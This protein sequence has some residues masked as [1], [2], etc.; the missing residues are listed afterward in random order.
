MMD[1]AQGM[2]CYVADKVLGT[3]KLPYGEVTIDLNHWERLTM[4]EAV[5]NMRAS[6]LPV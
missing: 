5:K 6:I 1:I 3:R 2:F 4:L